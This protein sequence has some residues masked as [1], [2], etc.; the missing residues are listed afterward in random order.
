ML[1]PLLSGPCSTEHQ[2]HIPEYNDICSDWRRT[3]AHLEKKQEEIVIKITGSYHEAEGEFI[4]HFRSDGYLKIDYHF[5]ALIDIKPRQTGIV[6]DLDSALTTLRWHRQAQW[7]VYPD[8][9][10]GRADGIA[11]AAGEV[12]PGSSWS[13]DDHE[14]GCND[15]RSSKRNINL[16]ALGSENGMGL[17]VLGYGKKTVRAFMSGGR[18]HMLIADYSTGGA[19]LFIDTH[20][21]GERLRIKKGDRVEGSCLLR[22]QDIR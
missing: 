14:L 8:D 13:R 17:Q 19:D 20:Y 16:A 21:A 1:L 12:M 15:F 2:K 11:R 10:I 22:I 9:H 3:S 4:Y 5:T 7:S 18:A 6:M